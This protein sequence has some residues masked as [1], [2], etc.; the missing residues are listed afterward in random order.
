M[1]G[2]AIISI[3]LAIAVPTYQRQMIK[4]HREHAKAALVSVAAQIAALRTR[5]ANANLPNAIDP[6]TLLTHPL[7]RYQLQLSP[8]PIGNAVIYWLTAVPSDPV[9]QGDGG[10]TLSDNGRGCWHQST[11]TPT[12]YQCAAGEKA[13]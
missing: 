9:Q 11:D 6:Q 4:S 10:L 1:I 12:D 3:L 8:N 7:P 13:W 2:L 5:S